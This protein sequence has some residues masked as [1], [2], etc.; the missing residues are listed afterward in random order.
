VAFRAAAGLFAAALL[1]FW[2]LLVKPQ[3]TP[4]AADQ[5]PKSQ[6]PDACGD[7]VVVVDPFSTGGVLAAELLRRGYQVIAL[8][9]HESGTRHHDYPEGLDSSQLLAELEEVATLQATGEELRQVLGRNTL[10]AVICGGDSGVKLAD[11]LSEVMD[12]RGNEPLRDGHRRDKLLQQKLVKAAGL[13]SARTVSGTQWEQVAAFAETEQYPVVLKPIES[14]G[15]DGFKL[16]HSTEEA[17]EH[18]EFLNQSSRWCGAQGSDVLLQEFLQG[19]EYVV[20]HVSCDGLHKT[21]MLWMYDFQ[22][23][24]GSRVCTAQQPISCDTPMARELTAYTRRCLDALSVR[25][26]AS[27]TE[28]MW[29]STG[30]CLVEVNCRCQGGSGFW[31]PLC[32]KMT[33]YSQL[34]VCIDAFLRP[35]AFKALPDTPEFLMSGIIIHLISYDEN[36]VITALPGIETVRNLSSFTNLDMNVHVGDRARRTTD[37][38]TMCGVVAFCHPDAAVLASHIS[39]LRSMELSGTFATV[40]Q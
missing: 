1:M 31:V 3:S 19:T 36:Y 22:T 38:Y 10:A 25:N 14:A 11:E 5:A 4:A 39:M 40:M 6:V 27:H 20:D 12:L 15:A 13:R 9:T 34:D 29:T 23:V 28:V 21:T 30:P 35:E 18:F 24:N 26:G 37:W 7:V 32:R 2:V 17:R 16:C 8:W 33:G